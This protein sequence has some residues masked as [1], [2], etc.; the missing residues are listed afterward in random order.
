MMQGKST[1]SRKNC[2]T[3]KPFSSDTERLWDDF[4]AKSPTGTLLHTRRF[5]SYH[6]SR[7]ADHSL[8]FFDK[9]GDLCAVLPAAA[10][11][12]DPHCI[13]S[14][15]GATYGGLVLSSKNHHLIALEV[16]SIACGY[17]ANRGFHRMLYKAVP[18]HLHA[19]MNQIDLYALWRMGARLYRRDL[20][21]VIDLRCRG[22]VTKGRQYQLRRASQHGIRIITA[23]SES[24]YRRFYEIL[25]AC[26][27]QR[28][29]VSPV[30]SLEELL[31]LQERFLDQIE[32]WLALDE[33]ENCLAGSWVFDLGLAR[34]WQYGAA[35]V[36]GRKYSAQ[37]LL[38]ETI[39]EHSA[40]KGA[41]YFSFGTSTEQEGQILNCG[42]FKYKSS[43]GAGAVTQDFY[44]IDLR[45]ISRL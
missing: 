19:G 41:R 5:L 23:N 25:V 43:F 27:D 20:W 17:F 36:N 16:L 28:H 22:P 7:F 34:H 26:L 14:H 9:L 2:I 12:S 24:H 35:S 29:D 21:S 11:P 37:D 6:G 15:P 18:P 8:L 44:E 45:G 42:L 32:L 40:Q 33:S 3:A 30:H 31:L 1:E 38:L 13:V 39:M 10:N 4:V